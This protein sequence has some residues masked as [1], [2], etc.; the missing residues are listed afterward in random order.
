MQQV[1]ILKI[2]CTSAYTVNGLPNVAAH[3][4]C[5]KIDI[6]VKTLVVECYFL[7]SGPDQTSM[8]YGR[9]V[10]VVA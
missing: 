6:H 2:F 7:H 10:P 9:S 5:F 3:S 8:G 4:D 1:P